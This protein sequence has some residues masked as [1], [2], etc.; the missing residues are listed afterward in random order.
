[1]KQEAADGYVEN[2]PLQE[3]AVTLA[4]NTVG[5]KAKSPSS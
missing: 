4:K 3:K 1:L 5:G 2:L